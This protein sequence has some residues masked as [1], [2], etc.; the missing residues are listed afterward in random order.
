MTHLSP[1]LK[2]PVFQYITVAVSANTN[3][4]KSH[5]FGKTHKPVT[6]G[7]SEMDNPGFIYYTVEKNP[8]MVSPF[9]IVYLLLNPWTQGTTFN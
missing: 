8:E 1:S 6:S 3:E 2:Y 5:T 7:F 9:L 4:T